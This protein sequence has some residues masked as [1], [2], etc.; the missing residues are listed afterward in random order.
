MDEK[1][2]VLND[3]GGVDC[4]KNCT[5]EEQEKCIH[6]DCMRAHP[7]SVGGLGECYKL[8]GKTIPNLVFDSTLGIYKTAK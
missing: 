5:T 8:K 1:E 6:F 7:K 2:V 3:W 4:R